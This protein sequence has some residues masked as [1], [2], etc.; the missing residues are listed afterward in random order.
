[1]HAN[2]NYITALLRLDASVGLQRF[3][4]FITALIETIK[5]YDQTAYFQICQSEMEVLEQE[6]IERIIAKRP[7]KIKR[8]TLAMMLAFMLMLIV[9]IVLQIVTTMKDVL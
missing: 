9:P 7:K 1:M 8:A 4:P 5:G 6:N 3:T 2:A